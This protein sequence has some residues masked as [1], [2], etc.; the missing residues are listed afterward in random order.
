M[1]DLLLFGAS[2]D[3]DAQA[4]QAAVRG[5]G[6]AVS[7][8]RLALVSAFIKG[9]KASG[10]WGSLDRLWLY[11]GENSTQARRDLVAR[12][13]ASAVNGPAFTAN[14][15]YKGDGLSAYIDTGFNVSTAARFSQ[16]SAG[17]GGWIETADT[18]N[19]DRVF[20][21][22]D[23]N[24][25]ELNVGSPNFAYGI[26]QAS[27]DGSSV[28]VSSTGSVHINRSGA[29]ATSFSLNGAQTATS[30]TASTAVPNH[31]LFGLASNQTV[32]GAVGFSTARLAAQ[33]ASGSLT[34]T[35]I[36]DLHAGLRAF[37]TAVG[38]A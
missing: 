34:A 11:A 19:T 21:Y 7:A 26:N 8:Q 37:M 36:A 23:N 24:Y 33:W 1:L 13:Q 18:T 9:R 30:A 14:R 15:G 12:T 20:G 25:G 3:I 35:Q 22:D 17:F 2:V 5:A 31:N 28:A 16:N 6:A 38:V 29:S 32:A 27:A 10:V 4:W